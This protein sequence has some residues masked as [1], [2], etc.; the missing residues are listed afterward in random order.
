MRVFKH[1]IAYL[2]APLLLL[3]C[4]APM[5]HETVQAPQ[6]WNQINPAPTEVVCRVPAIAPSPSKVKVVNGV[7]WIQLDGEIDQSSKRELLFKLDTIRT[8]RPRAKAVVLEI[9]STGGQ[10]AEGLEMAKALERSPV[11]VH[12]V[13]DGDAMSMAFFIL[14]ACHT[15]S[16]TIR[17][18]LMTH[19]PA[20]K[21]P[22]S[23]CEG[24]QYHWRSCADGL[25][26]MTDG[27]VW[28]SA[29]RMKMSRSAFLRR[30]AGQDWYMSASQALRFHAV[31]QLV[32]DVPEVIRQRSSA[33]A[34]SSGAGGTAGSTAHS[35]GSRTDRSGD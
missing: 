31:D 24:D 23:G 2:I 14:Q 8:L 25:K 22:V 16:M 30:I 21:G 12:C 26:T 9:N 20:I 7:A 3:V 5:H 29:K 4:C 11:K 28:F 34:R 15:R 19:Q 1:R 35:R 27:W 6:T 33:G 18:R 13:V 32:Q 10:V 17:S